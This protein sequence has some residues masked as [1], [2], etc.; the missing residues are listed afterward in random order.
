MVT[1]G[2]FCFFVFFVFGVS[3]SGRTLSLHS[4][5]PSTDLLTAISFLSG[6]QSAIVPRTWAILKDLYQQVLPSHPYMCERK[7]VNNHIPTDVTNVNKHDAID[8]IWFI[9]F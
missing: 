9:V 1:G 4:Y 7:T 6:A 5:L 2:F 3:G 8:K